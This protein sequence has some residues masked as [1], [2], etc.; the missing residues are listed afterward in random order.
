MTISAV[1]WTIALKSQ[2]G[3]LVSQAVTSNERRLVVRC[4]RRRSWSARRS[5][6]HRGR[7]FA[8]RRG[9]ELGHR[10]KICS[11]LPA[12]RRYNR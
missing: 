1:M 7:N 6:R 4:E 11:G 9:G 8:G 5:G 10:A 3:A 2:G 12:A